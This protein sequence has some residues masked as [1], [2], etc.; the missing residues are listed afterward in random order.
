M[1]RERVEIEMK[2]KRRTEKRWLAGLLSI[3]LAF[4]LLPGT[5]LAEGDNLITTEFTLEKIV[6][7]GGLAAPPAETFTFELTDTARDPK[8]LSDYGI[9][10][11]ELTISTKD[12]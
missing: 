10:M 4:C 1:Y 2:H 7:K 5:A 8:P 3:V 6:K 9:T 11:D 12:A